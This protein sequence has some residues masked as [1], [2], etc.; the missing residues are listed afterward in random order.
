MVKVICDGVEIQNAEVRAGELVVPW[1]LELSYA[2]DSFRQRAGNMR[3][4]Y[5]GWRS[6]LIKHGSGTHELLRLLVTAPGRMPEWVEVRV[7]NFPPTGQFT[8][9]SIVLPP[10]PSR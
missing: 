6:F 3:V 4:D 5:Q 1:L 8:T 9:Q 7:M 2:Q 10:A